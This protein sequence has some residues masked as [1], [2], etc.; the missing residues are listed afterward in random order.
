[1]ALTLKNVVMNW[2]QYKSSFSIELMVSFVSALEKQ[3]NESIALYTN[4]AVCHKA[5]RMG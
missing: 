3:A 4:T 5:R 2:Y 1:M